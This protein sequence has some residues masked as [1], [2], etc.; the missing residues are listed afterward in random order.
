MISTMSK[1]SKFCWKNWKFKFFKPY[2]GYASEMFRSGFSQLCSNFQQV[3]KSY[4][5]KIKDAQME[6]N[7]KNEDFEILNNFDHIKCVF[8]A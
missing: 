4:I 1:N 5:G 6:K 2:L 8:R 7:S 3:L